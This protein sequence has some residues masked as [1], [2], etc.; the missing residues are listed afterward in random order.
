MSSLVWPI[1]V[2]IFFAS[3]AVAALWGYRAYTTG[4]TS[5]SLSWL[6]P[7]RPEP[8]LAVMEQ[9][10]VDGKRKL[11]LIRRDDVEHLIMTGG[12]V[13]V[14]IETGIASHPREIAAPSREEPRA[15]R[16]DPTAPVFTRAPRGFGHAV[17]E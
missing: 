7:P 3:A 5:F 13:D 15:E 1:F 4:D 8:R 10:S 2:V 14:V 9:A 11:V 6:F 16:V 17:N 12:P